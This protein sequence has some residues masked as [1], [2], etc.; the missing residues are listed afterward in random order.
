M[1]IWF[2]TQFCSS[3]KAFR[4]PAIWLI[5]DSWPNK[6]PLLSHLSLPVAFI[7][8]WLVLRGDQNPCSKLYICYLIRTHASSYNYG[9]VQW[10]STEKRQLYKIHLQVWIPIKRFFSDQGREKFGFLLYKKCV[11]VLMLHKKSSDWEMYNVGHI[12]FFKKII[13]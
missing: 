5:H 1:V 13:Y 10:Q 8:G 7:V 3:Y 6:I 11:F 4:L 12:L 2:L 9:D